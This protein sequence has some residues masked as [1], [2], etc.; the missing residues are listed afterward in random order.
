MTNPESDLRARLEDAAEGLV[1]TSE[2][3]RPFEWFQLAGGGAG[4]P[5][6][7]DEFARRIGAPAGASLEERTLDRFFKPHIESTDPYD[8]RAQEIRP[9]Y[10]A[11]KKLLAANLRDV[12]VFRVGRIEIGCYVV[13]ADG[14]GNLAGLRTVAVET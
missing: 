3:D 12:R 11:L 6:G 10:E 4:W 14:Q 2:S 5:Y 13:G 1:Y 9:R 7:A 8:T